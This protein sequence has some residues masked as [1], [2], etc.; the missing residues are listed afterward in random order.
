MPKLLN[1]KKMAFLNYNKFDYVYFDRILKIA[2]IVPEFYKT[3][4]QVVAIERNFVVQAINPDH[5]MLLK[6]LMPADG[7]VSLKMKG[8]PEQ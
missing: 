5:V 4:Q 7:F 6:D 8:S 2:K 3:L 1:V